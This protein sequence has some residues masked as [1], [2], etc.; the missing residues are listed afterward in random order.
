MKL[1]EAVIEKSAGRK[2]KRDD[3]HG[4]LRVVDSN[5]KLIANELRP[6]SSVK[7]ILGTLHH[8]KGGKLLPDVIARLTAMH[9]EGISDYVMIGPSE[10]STASF[11]R[12]GDAD[13]AQLHNHIMIHV[14]HRVGLRF[15]REEIWDV[16][17][18]N[19]NGDGYDGGG[20]R[21][22]V[23]RGTDDEARDYALKEMVE[24]ESPVLELGQRRGTS[25]KQGQRGELD[26]F[27]R[28]V[29]DGTVSNV[30]E[31][32]ELHSLVYAKFPN[33]VVEYIQKHALVRPVLPEGYRLKVWQYYLIEQLKTEP[34]DRT[35]IIHVDPIG[36][37]GKSWF[38]KY[39]HQLLPGKFVQ[40]LR[41]GRS[42]DMAKELDTRADVILCDVPREVTYDADKK[43]MQYRIFEE[44]KDG[45]VSST[46]YYCMTKVMK[47]CHV[48]IFMNAHPTEGVLSEDR[49]CIVNITNALREFHDE[50]AEPADSGPEFSGDE[51]GDGPKQ[52]STTSYLDDIRRANRNPYERPL[53]QTT[54]NIDGS[55]RERRPVTTTNDRTLGGY[56]LSSS[57]MG[58]AFWSRGGFSRFQLTRHEFLLTVRKGG[59]NAGLI[60]YCVHHFGWDQSGSLE[61][62]INFNNWPTRMRVFNSKIDMIDGTDSISPRYVTPD[63][64]V[65]RL[66]STRAIIEPPVSPVGDN[67]DTWGMLHALQI[68]CGNETGNPNPRVDRDVLGKSDG[69]FNAVEINPNPL[70][71]VDDFMNVLS[72]M[73]PECFINRYMY[74]EDS[75]AM[76]NINGQFKRRLLGPSNRL[77]VEYDSDGLPVGNN[78]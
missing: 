70:T 29:R 76:G 61:L 55:E 58:T 63:G 16:L 10:Q 9:G 18:S 22:L 75:E 65:Y 52:F 37:S 32:M 4:G 68:S 50:P 67:R 12:S 6:G 1:S 7:K 11:E 13:D 8:D 66:K 23:Q 19:L 59:S 47:P 40:K 69:A 34:D 38:C 78:V 15:V 5:G 51:A 53:V 35:I 56:R 27:K 43:V 60:D 33:F 46:K 42:V 41:P 71:C 21:W 28:D 25:S 74:S 26:D 49:L 39:I 73:K 36:N 57:G 14:D 24:G 54:I 3:S 20:I 48:V 45:E 2:R 31:A 77:D 17:D 62:Y 72:N 64:I 44:I 30:V